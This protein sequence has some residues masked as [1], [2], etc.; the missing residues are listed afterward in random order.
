ME[1]S[2]IQIL[3]IFFQI[4]STIS[5]E[6]ETF[7][8]L[9]DLEN[10]IKNQLMRVSQNDDFS[11]NFHKNKDDTSELNILE[12]GNNLPV[13]NISVQS[14]L[15]N[16][17]DLIKIPEE[18]VGNIERF[19]FI[20]RE[21]LS[22]KY[23]NSTIRFDKEF[24]DQSIQ[25]EILFTHKNLIF[26]SNNKGIHL[27]RYFNNFLVEKEVKD[28]QVQL[29]NN[30]S[31]EGKLFNS[32]KMI[33]SFHNYLCFFNI[34]ESDNFLHEIVLKNFLG[35]PNQF[36]DK[37]L[38]SFFTFTDT[39]LLVYESSILIV[40]FQFKILAQVKSF[41]SMSESFNLHI[42]QAHL[43]NE[44]LYVLSVSFGMLVYSINKKNSLKLLT[45]IRNP[46]IRGFTIE[47]DKINFV[48]KGTRSQ[49]SS[50]EVYRIIVNQTSFEYEAKINIKDLINDQESNF[51]GKLFKYEGFKVIFSKSYKTL[52]F[53]DNDTNAILMSKLRLD[54]DEDSLIDN[55]FIL[56]MESEKH[57]GIV[58]NNKKVLIIKNLKAGQR[59]IDFT[60]LE[61]G[62]YELKM[63]AIVET[64]K[65]G[66]KSLYISTKVNV[67]NL[68]K[69]SNIYNESYI[70]TAFYIMIG[71]LLIGIFMVITSSI[72]NY[73]ENRNQRNMKA[74][75]S[76]TTSKDKTVNNQN[77]EEKF[78]LDIEL[79]IK[80]N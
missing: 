64:I 62:V 25:G 51:E 58:L 7:Y 28:L 26:T 42:T 14:V 69:L 4:V 43:V 44:R 63:K 39:I 8:V 17:S 59:N 70:Y 38:I 21:I 80:S 78:T 3:I 13:F 65:E 35:V 23:Y 57:M 68:N 36:Q 47:G 45:K 32:G 16:S 66:E 29:L 52:Q 77:E 24:H 22:I 30:C 37:N 74:G 10:H 67:S 34:E 55:V 75:Y 73:F 61:Y 31:L 60:F 15:H 46:S 71:I 41:N 53:W 20:N 6:E 19:S 50:L 1:I 56:D 49:Q 54:E 12:N 11:T 9:S 40:D 76:L 33:L 2:L 72:Y 18:K 79:E 48:N 27:Y 5:Q